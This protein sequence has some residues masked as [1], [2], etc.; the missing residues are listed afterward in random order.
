ML[1]ILLFEKL[2]QLSKIL[3]IC[4]SIL[5]CLEDTVSL[6]SSIS[7]DF[8]NL[9]MA[10]SAK[11][12]KTKVSN[13]YNNQGISLPKTWETYVYNI[14]LERGSSS[15]SLH[16]KVKNTKSKQQENKQK[17]QIQQIFPGW[18]LANADVLTAE[19][20]GHLELRKNS[21]YWAHSID[22]PSL[23]SSILFN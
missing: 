1:V 23:T 19:K 9:S 17:N 16:G 4:E 20:E 2:R 13:Y 10:S 3:H 18:Y 14:K 22:L 7:S 21:M 5:L 6:V 15:P 11:I 8:H 12:L